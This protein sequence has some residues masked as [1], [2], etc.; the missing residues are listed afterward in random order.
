MHKKQLDNLLTLSPKE[1]YDYFIRYCA[2]FEELWALSVNDNWIIFKD[3]D[4]DEVCPLWTHYDLAMVCMF[5]EH[6]EMGAKP[7][8][9]DLDSFMLECIPD[10]ISQNI[11][12]GVFF[13]KNREGLIVDGEKLRKDLEM[14][15]QEVWN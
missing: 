15:I 1:R 6:K 9:I 11:Y 7:K 13:D 12:F 10:M 14:E 3:I 2:D 4:S 5:K 8:K